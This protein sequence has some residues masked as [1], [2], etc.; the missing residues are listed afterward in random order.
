MSRG[1]SCLRRGR[2]RPQLWSCKSQLRGWQRDCCLSLPFHQLNTLHVELFFLECLRLRT[3]SP[4]LKCSG[5]LPQHPIQDSPV[6]IRMWL[7]HSFILQASTG[8]SNTVL[9]L[10]E[11]HPCA[12]LLHSQERLVTDPCCGGEGLLLSPSSSGE[13]DGLSLL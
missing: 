6:P 4:S 10:P 13:T 3:V 11:G 7:L 1:L 12:T 5:R 8:S 2:P 9:S